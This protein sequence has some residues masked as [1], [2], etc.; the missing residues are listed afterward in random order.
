MARSPGFGS[1]TS[2]YS[3]LLRLAFAAARISC[4]TSPADRDSAA[5][6][7]KAR[8]HPLTGS[9]FLWACGFRFSFTP[10]PGVLFTFPSRYWFAIGHRVVFS[11]SGWSPMIPRIPRAPPSQVPPRRMSSLRIRVSHP[12]RIPFPWDSLT[13]HVIFIGG[14]TTPDYVRFGLLRFRSPL[15]TESTSL[16]LPAGT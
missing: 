15:L 9:D 16:S 10:L 3:A 14:P 13:L 6:S 8:H 5:H 12:L 7:T 2:D 4:L 1:T 11:L